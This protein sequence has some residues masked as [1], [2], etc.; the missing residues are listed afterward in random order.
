MASGD[1]Y[2]MALI[3]IGPQG[4]ELVNVHHYRQVAAGGGD[5]GDQLARAWIEDAAPLW[6]TCVSANVSMTEIQIRNVTQP[7]FGVD[8][9]TDLPVA[10]TQAGE[11]L[12]PNTTF[13]ISW[14]TGLIG[15][16]RRGRTFMFPTVEASQAS[17]QISGGQA[18][19]M[20]AYA[21]EMLDLEDPDTTAT[22]EMVIHSEVPGVGDTTVNTF[23]IPQFIA[24]QRR[25]RA[26]TGS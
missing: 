4:Q 8:W 15:R 6:A 23:L 18:V 2:R 26:G 25:R 20:E 19:A 5:L 1:I 11:T 21:T 7:Q 13:V 17:G 14:R 24:T 22:F 12:P 3:G 9:S 10:G 16:S